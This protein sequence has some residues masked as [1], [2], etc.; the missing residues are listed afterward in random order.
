MQQNSALVNFCDEAEKIALNDLALDL[1]TQ[2]K[3]KDNGAMIAPATIARTGIMEYTAKQC[4]ALFADRDPNSIVRIMT[5]PADLFDEA[6]LE[7]YHSA[8]IT[9]GHPAEDVTTDNSKELQKGHLV[10]VPFAD[11]EGGML[12]ANIV[13]SDSEAV[14]TVEAGTSQLSSGHSCVLV[15]ADEGEDFDAKKTNIR[16]NHVAIVAAGRA[17]TAEIADS[18]EV[19]IVKAKLTDAEETISNKEKELEATQAKLDDSVE[20]VNALEVKLADEK[21]KFE[22]AVASAVES[23]LAFLQIATPLTDKDINS[24]GEK[25]AKLLILKDSLGKDFGNKS[26]A[27]IDARFDAFVES[28]VDDDMNS[29]AAVLA[30]DAKNRAEIKGKK[31]PAKNLSAR[32]NMIKRN[33]KS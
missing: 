18:D 27:Y 21:A 4:G 22:D 33:S 6:S 30:D 14:D 20:K 13:L 2:R 8:P 15:M 24:L 10:G 28:N 5:E 19:E 31:T 9:I 16:A 1:P 11:E 3:F 7:S 29:I 32:E 17:G 23:K 25:D 26:D 12:A